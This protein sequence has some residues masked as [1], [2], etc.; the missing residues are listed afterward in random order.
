MKLNQNWKPKE[1]DIH[2]LHSNSIYLNIHSFVIL[3]ISYKIR[4][5]LLPVWVQSNAQVTSKI[6]GAS[7]KLILL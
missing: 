4:Y 1:F 2:F 3:N 6:K 5:K 7:C